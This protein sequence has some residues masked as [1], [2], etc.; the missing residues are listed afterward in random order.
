[1]RTLRG[2]RG[3]ILFVAATSWM[4]AGPAPARASD[5]GSIYQV[6]PIIDGVTIGASLALAGTM[7]AF[8]NGLIDVRCPCDRNNVNSF[9]RFAIGFHSNAAAWVSD[10]TVGAA[11]LAPV[12]LDWFAL[13]DLRIFAEDMTVYAEALSISGALNVVA[14]QLA[15]RPFPRTYAGDPKL[16]SSTGGYHSFYSGHTTL[17]FTALS[18]ASVTIG[19]RYGYKVLPWLVTLVVGASVAIERVAAGWH[20]P[21]D[22]LTGAAVGTAI[23]IAVP[24]IHLRRLGI[25]P[26]ASLFPDARTAGLGLTGGWN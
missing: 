20:F 6:H 22:V 19:E 4:L 10:V 3:P 21:T 23:G 11:L 24:V 14:K 13:G 2:A 16:V 8:G 26:S 12:A 1:M 15:G 25:M 5:D 18:V 17:T 7:Y 9:D